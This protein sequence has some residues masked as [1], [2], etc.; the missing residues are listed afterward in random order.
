MTA[1]DYTTQPLEAYVAEYIATTLGLGVL[2]GN[3][4]ASIFVGEE[5]PVPDSCMTVFLVGGSPLSEMLRTNLIT[6]RARNN[7]Y[8]NVMGMLNEVQMGLTPASVAHGGLLLGPYGV[9][10]ISSTAPA[11]PLGRD[12]GDKGGRWR[13]SQTFEITTHRRFALA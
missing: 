10:R 7:Q 1:V 6:V 5:P 13:A 11:L 9:A 8:Q 2:W 12:G 3:D 4:D